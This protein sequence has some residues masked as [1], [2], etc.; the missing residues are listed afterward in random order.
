MYSECLKSRL[1]L[2]QQVQ[3]MDTLDFE[4][5]LKSRRPLVQ[6]PDVKIVPHK[7]GSLSIS[8]IFLI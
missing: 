4:S 3:F 8:E 1:E 6:N 2:P 7:S 5:C